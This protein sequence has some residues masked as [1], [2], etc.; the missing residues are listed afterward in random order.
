MVNITVPTGAILV[1][2]DPA[3]PILIAI[4]SFVL[5]I[6]VVILVRNPPIDSSEKRGHVTT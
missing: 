1:L 2:I 4:T 3:V 5:V 6:V